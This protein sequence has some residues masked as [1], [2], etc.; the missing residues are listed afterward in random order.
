MKRNGFTMVELIFV[1]IIIGI[2]SVAAIP[3]FGD[4]KDRAKAS[5]E[6]GA[7][8][9]L[10]SVIAA[11]M[12][13]QLEDH[14][15]IFVNWH[16]AT[17]NSDL[18]NTYKD[19]N[20]NKTVLGK[21]L[22]KNENLKIVAYADAGAGGGDG[23]YDDIFFIKGKASDATLGA[24]EA[25]SAGNLNGKPDKT[26]VWVFNA[27]PE[28]ATVTYHNGTAA[29]TKVL[30]SGEIALI[31]LTKKAADT[32]V[33]TAD[34]VDSAGEIAVSGVKNDGT[35]GDLTIVDSGL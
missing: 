23:K 35:T 15:N 3:K 22:K 2:L 7:L 28:Q 18:N 10:D 11:N 19:V 20:T 29:K 1:I 16:N 26:D 32:F 31:D 9:G 21:I 27:S 4:I 14:D 30:E 34:G 5:T 33:D 8:S 17:W 24:K 13:M 6:Y 12:E 25:D